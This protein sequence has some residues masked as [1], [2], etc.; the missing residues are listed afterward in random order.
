MAR[1]ARRR[2]PEGMTL[3]REIPLEA[4]VAQHNESLLTADALQRAILNSAS[5]CSIATDAKG[6][7]QIF[8]LGAERML[9]YAAA[10]CVNCLT[11]ADF[12]DPQEVIT[13]ARALSAEFGAPIAP[14]VDAFVFKASREI[15][16]IYELTYIRKDGSRFPAV[17]SITALRDGNE[18]I[19]GYLLIGTDNTERV[20]VEDERKKLDQRPH[21]RPLNASGFARDT[22]LYVE[23]N[24]ANLMLVERFMERRPDLNLVSAGDALAGVALARLGR[25]TVILMDVNLPVI[26]GI[27]ALA[28][29]AA[30]EETKHIPVVA[31]SANAMPTDV[32]HG[33]DSGFFRYLTK[34][35][36]APHL[37]AA[38]DEAIV[39]AKRRAAD[40]AWDRQT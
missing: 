38:L 27:D 16:D 20:R 5:F 33:L 2:N 9:G 24:P 15:Q 22:I 11:P 32:A 17:V 35:I 14:G 36:G 30:H 7:I 25:P 39:L 29:L 21:D 4:A 23:D 6:V 37:F 13:R 8:N 12:S 3:V 10:D 28:L 1:G 18:A 19:I 31:L 26:S 40:L 34:P